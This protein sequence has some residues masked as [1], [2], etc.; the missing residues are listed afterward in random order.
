MR[1]M[2]IIRCSL[3]CSKRRLSISKRP[4]N[5]IR[6]RS[7]K[8]GEIFMIKAVLFDFDGVLTIDKTGST[9]I[10][11]YISDNCDIPLERVKSLITN[12]ISNYYWEK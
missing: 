12:S 2:D 1:R 8:F 6:R 9:T 7:I 3:C 11:N 10:T 5:I 4:I